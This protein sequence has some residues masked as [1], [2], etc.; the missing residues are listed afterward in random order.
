VWCC[1]RPEK[2]LLVTGWRLDFGDAS[3]ELFSFFSSHSSCLDLLRRRSGGGTPSVIN[4]YCDED[5]YY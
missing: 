5:Y 4:Y 2:I 1:P 3:L